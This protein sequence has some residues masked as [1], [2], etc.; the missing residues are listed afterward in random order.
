MS[1]KSQNRE[2]WK[3]RYFEI[4]SENFPEIMKDI[5]PQT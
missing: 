2:W 1:L 3:K 5:K 4:V